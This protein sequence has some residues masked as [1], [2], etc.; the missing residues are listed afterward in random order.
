MAVQ[1]IFEENFDS[2]SV[3]LAAAIARIEAED[4]VSLPLL[5][6][7]HLQRLCAASADLSFRPAKPLVGEGER[8]VQ[9]EFEICITVPAHNPLWDFAAALSQ[10]VNSALARLDPSPLGPPFHFNDLAVQHYPRGSLGI[11]P[12]RDHIRYQG[13]VAI[14]TLSGAAR[15]FLSTD[16]AGHGE[17]EVPCP[18]GHLLLMR[19]PGFAGSQARPFHCL[20]EVAHTRLGLGLRYDTQAA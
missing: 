11:T 3:S 12:H 13:L 5:K 7:A 16:R 18:P 6:P 15:F 19:A 10:M 20:R 17:R 2:A 9:Q 1:D 14:V 4:A 8:A